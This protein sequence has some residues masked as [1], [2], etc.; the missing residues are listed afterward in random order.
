MS[1]PRMVIKSVKVPVMWEWSI[2]CDV[3]AI[4]RSSI[5][6]PSLEYLNDMGDEDGKKIAFGACNHVYHL[7]CI[8][9][10][11]KSRQNCPLCNVEWEYKNIVNSDQS[12]QLN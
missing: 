8:K 5:S 7:D 9:K 10:T 6:G 12:H 4:C 1:Q 2:S 3:C 11:L